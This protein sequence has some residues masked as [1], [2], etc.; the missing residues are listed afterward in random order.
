[1]DYKKPF[2][3]LD[4]S[5]AGFAGEDI[6][7]ETL[8]ESH[9]CWRG[10]NKGIV[11]PYE[12]ACKHEWTSNRTDDEKKRLD[13]DIEVTLHCEGC[14]YAIEH[15]VTEFTVTQRHEVKSNIAAYD[16]SVTGGS[17]HTGNVY[18]ELIQ[19]YNGKSGKGWYTKYVEAYEAAEAAGDEEAK[20][21]AF[22][23]WIHFYEPY[24][25]YER[26]GLARKF[27][28]PLF[29]EIADD[30]VIAAWEADPDIDEGD[31]LITKWPLEQCVSVRGSQLYKF[32]K[33][34]LKNNIKG[35]YE[36]PSG[37]GILV[38]IALLVSFV[39]ADENATGNSFDEVFKR[40]TDGMDGA[41][42]TAVWEYVVKGENGK[43]RKCCL[44]SWK[45][46]GVFLPPVI[47]E[48]WVD[49]GEYSETPFDNS[50]LYKRN[51]RGKRAYPNIDRYSWLQLPEHR[52]IWLEAGSFVVIGAIDENGTAPIAY[53][54]KGKPSEDK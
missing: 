7:L 9:M 35:I 47:M 52:Y 28:E 27:S 13:Y 12:N 39:V 17:S 14:K 43:R 50:K 23:E 22:P 8:K 18:L 48:Q 19:T 42:D 16:E 25:H 38:A 32:V 40:S 15:G 2:E 1:M 36:L 33:R 54:H 3:E 21:K 30:A 45:H 5:R 4:S 53:G 34:G 6:V 51:L 46:K 49:K 44:P 20:R 41:R 37:D 26:E 31:V 11:C 24:D 29:T 10:D